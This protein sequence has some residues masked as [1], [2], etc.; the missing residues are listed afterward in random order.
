MYRLEKILAQFLLSMI[1]D[2]NWTQTGDRIKS[3]STCL[4]LVLGSLQIRSMRKKLA[5]ENSDILQILELQNWCG[6]ISFIHTL[7]I[8]PFQSMVLAEFWHFQGMIL[9]VNYRILVTVLSPKVIHSVSNL[10]CQLRRPWILL[11]SQL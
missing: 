10:V 1:I 4:A 6:I 11:E 7:V 8:I 2:P 3:Y 5:T 9:S